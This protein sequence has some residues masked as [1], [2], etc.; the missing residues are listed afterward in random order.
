GSASNGEFVRVGDAGCG[1]ACGADDVYR[2]TAYDTSYTIARFN[3][4]GSQ[5]T[6]LLLQNP[7]G[8]PVDGVVRYWSPNGSLVGAASFTLAAHGG[9]TI[10]TAATLSGL[11]GAITV[12]S[13]A[14]Y[15]TLTGKAVSL[16]PATGFSFDT[17]MVPRPR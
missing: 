7:T 16:E 3:N 15:G 12:A 6:V 11:S 10:N 5:V 8:D 17:P 14:P 2:I 1:S 4:T 13:L 9:K